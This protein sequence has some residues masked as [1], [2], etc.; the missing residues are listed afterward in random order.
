VTVSPSTGWASGPE[1][2]GKLTGMPAEPASHPAGAMPPAPGSYAAAEQYRAADLEVFPAGADLALVYSRDTGAAAFHRP[3]IVELLTGLR[4]FRTVEQHL[5]DRP[6]MPADTLRR[7]LIGLCRAG[8][9]VPRHRPLAGGEDKDNDEPVLPISTVGFPTRDRVDVLRRAI[10]SYAENCARH[11]R[12]PSFAVLDDSAAA[13]TRARYRAMLAELGEHHR[14]DIHYAGLPEKERF[15]AELAAA[16]SLPLEVAGHACLGGQSRNL[17]TIGANRNCLLLHSVGERILSADDDTVCRLAS[18]PDRDDRVLLR[19]AENPLDTWYFADRA[20]A[21]GALRHVEQDLLGRHEEYLGRSPAAA[22]AGVEAGWELA[23]PALLR[24]L[25]S[26]AGR[27]LVTSNG[28]V[29]DC[30]WDNPNFHLFAEDDS[31]ARLT[32]SA[33]DYRQARSSR[34]LAQAVSRPTITE[35]P[36]P[37]F[38]MC[39]GMDNTELLAPFPPT[40]RAEEIAFGAVLARCHRDGYG[41]HLPWLVQ[42]DPVGERQFADRSIFTI[43]LGSWLPACVGRY[44]PGACT[45]PAGRLRGL[46]GYLIDLGRLPAAEF[47]GYVRFTVWESMSALVGRLTERLD[48]AEPVPDY[49]AADARRFIATVRRQALAPVTELYSEVGG[50]DGLQRSLVRFGEVLSWWPRLVTAAQ[51]LRT[52][53]VRLAQPVAS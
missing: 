18:P 38:A 16:G 27:I 35:H 23:E 50:R 25:R 42:H 48:G 47:D 37:R 21:F 10:A 52:A 45:D 12:R 36:D 49:W 4:E 1:T 3:E 5:R 40:G 17:P 31:F 46:G 22:L 14:I 8:F 11:G 29:G 33:A 26:R 6:G 32:R 20:A 9:L 34:E 43:G 30:G 39:L 51:E 2:G 53:G 19:S 44:D 28:T 7:E 13:D 15:V 41:A 24:R